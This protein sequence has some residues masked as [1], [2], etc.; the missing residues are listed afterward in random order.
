MTPI[1]SL[2]T[3]TRNRPQDLLRLVHSIEQH[4]PM[5]WELVVSDASDEPID[6]ALP[7]A[8]VVLPERPRQGCTRGYNRAFRHARG[9][10]VIWLNDDCEVLPGYAENAIRFMEVNPRIGLGALPYSNKGGP[11]LTNSNSFD[12]M[13]YANFGII[14]RELGEQIGWFDEIVEH[15]GC[16]NSIGFRVLLAGLGIAEI[17]NARVIHYEHDDIHRHENLRNQMAD[18]NRLRAKYETLLPQM[19]EVY[20]RCRLVTA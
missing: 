6:L 19:R 5:S 1:L 2:V 8:V 16:D 17:P 11:F 12:G 13:L 15:Y 14:R 7:S 4:T 10:W 20:E 3:G 18:A 9:P